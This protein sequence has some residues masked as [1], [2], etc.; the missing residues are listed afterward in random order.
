MAIQAIQRAAGG[1]D[2]RPSREA[3]MA[4]SIS[5]RALFV[6]AGMSGLA[7]AGLALAAPM[8]ISV[9]LTGA[10][11]VPAVQTPGKGPAE[12]TYDPDTRIATWTISFTDLSGP[13]TMAHF[14]G[15]A[16]AGK[17]GPVIIWLS[18]KGS[19]AES[20]IKGEATLTPDQAKEFAAGEWYVNIHT[21]ENPA[22]E[23]R[24][25]VNPPKG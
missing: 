10:E 4:I 23:I 8:S 20:P 12:L 3:N 11:Q 5:R 19:M 16:M 24:G 25:Q 1:D 21:K 13:A 14:H 22:G 15:P 17:N 9:P 6:A 7:W 18:K 2:G